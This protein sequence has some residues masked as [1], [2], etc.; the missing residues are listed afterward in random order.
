VLYAWDA[1]VQLAAHSKTPFLLD[2][3]MKVQVLACPTPGHVEGPASKNLSE[4]TIELRIV[5]RVSR[6]ALPFFSSSLLLS[7]LVALGIPRQMGWI[8]ICIR[9]VLYLLEGQL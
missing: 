5:C 9:I 1:A 6:R 7:L 3:P 8:L 4:P 2:S